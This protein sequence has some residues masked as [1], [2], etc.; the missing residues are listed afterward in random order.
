M[1]RKSTSRY[2]RYASRVLLT[3]M[4]ALAAG[5]VLALAHAAPGKM[6]STVGSGFHG[7]DNNH[8]GY[9][10]AAESVLGDELAFRLADRDQDGLLNRDEYQQFLANLVQTLKKSGY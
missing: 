8:D 5:S 2:L 4:L 7:L 3:A 10:S 6:E 9:L 1:D